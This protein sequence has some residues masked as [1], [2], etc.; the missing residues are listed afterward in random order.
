MRV[1]KWGNSLAIRLP[2]AVV[3]ELALKEGD[4][5]DVHVSGERAFVVARE[6]RPTESATPARFQIPSRWGK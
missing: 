4:Q 6:Q 3:K 2:L 1:S 5:V